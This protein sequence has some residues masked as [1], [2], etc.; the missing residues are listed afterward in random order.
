YFLVN[1]I[2]AVLKHKN[3]SHIEVEEG[4]T[5]GVNDGGI[6]AVYTF[7][8]GKLVGD[9][10]P[11]LSADNDKIELEIVQ[12]KNEYGFGET[13]LQKLIDHLALLLSLD[14]DH[15][16]HVEF[17]SRLLERFEIFRRLYISATF[18]VLTVRVW[19][20]TKASDPPNIKV[21]KKSDRLN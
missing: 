14:P 13:P 3:L 21:K 16:L 18:A 15:E 10:Y 11:H 6:D 5:D 8:N 12:A 19:Y 2:D 20:L 1:S 9:E 17:N 7:L 4:I